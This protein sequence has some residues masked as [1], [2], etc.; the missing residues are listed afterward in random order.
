MIG[1]SLEHL[2]HTVNWIPSSPIVD[3]SLYILADQVHVK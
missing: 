3:I 2:D 1:K